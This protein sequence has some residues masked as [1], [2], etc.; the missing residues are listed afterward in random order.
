MVLGWLGVVPLMV[1]AGH[2]VYRFRTNSDRLWNPAF[3]LTLGAVTVY[4][5]SAV[6]PFLIYA[7]VG[8][9]FGP[10]RPPRPNPSPGGPSATVAGLV[11]FLLVFFLIVPLNYLSLFALSCFPP[12]RWGRP[13]RQRLR[14]AGCLGAVVA[15]ISLIS[16]VGFARDENRRR[17][18]ESFR[19]PP[20]AQP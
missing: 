16:I 10:D 17:Y 13:A 7:V 8:P 14:L 19:P 2:F 12:D 5:L 15:F 18:L 11:S 20:A 6:I 9:D 3:S 1:S 4:T